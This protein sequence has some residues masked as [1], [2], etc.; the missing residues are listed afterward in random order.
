MY[1]LYYPFEY[2]FKSSN[3]LSDYVQ[4]VLYFRY[5]LLAIMLEV[6]L[7]TITHLLLKYSSSIYTL[8]MLFYFPISLYRI[9]NKLTIKYRINLP[10]INK[11]ILYNSYIRWM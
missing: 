6:F 7:N 1:C 2:R 11:N 9:M 3:S 8:T 10:F 5:L 4:Y